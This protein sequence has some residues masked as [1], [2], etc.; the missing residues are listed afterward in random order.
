MRFGV[1]MTNSGVKLRA[2]LRSLGER[3]LSSQVPIL[4]NRRSPQC[5]RSLR[6]KDGDTIE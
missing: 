2:Q 6:L 4:R 5:G 1:Q 3:R